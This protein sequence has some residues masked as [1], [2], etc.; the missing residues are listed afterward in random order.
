MVLHRLHSPCGPSSGVRRR[1]VVVVPDPVAVE[2]LAGTIWPPAP[3]EPTARIK[4][5]EKLLILLRCAS[6]ELCQTVN[7]GFL[8][9][10]FF[11]SYAVS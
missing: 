9:E 6:A 7:I 1:P 4:L 10:K 5:M 11:S 8:T 3:L 2:E